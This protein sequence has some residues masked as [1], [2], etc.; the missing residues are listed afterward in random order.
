M[1]SAQPSLLLPWCFAQ[2]V[3]L[4]WDA[5]PSFLN[6]L[7]PVPPSGQLSPHSPALR[8]SPPPSTPCTLA[9]MMCICLLIAGLSP[10]SQHRKYLNS[11]DLD[12]MKD[13]SF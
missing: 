5:L 12:V 10:A 7:V 4:A 11:P 13:K 1:D 9:E 3:P 2:A 6:L 8:L